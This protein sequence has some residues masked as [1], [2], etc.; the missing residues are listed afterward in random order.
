[1]CFKLKLPKRAAIVDWATTDPQI[2]GTNTGFS[3]GSKG[4]T[5]N[6]NSLFFHNRI[7]RRCTR[8]NVG[9]GMEW[10]FRVCTLIDNSHFFFSALCNHTSPQRC[11]GSMSGMPVFTIS[12]GF[13][14]KAKWYEWV[15]QREGEP[16]AFETVR[17]IIES[18]VSAESLLCERDNCCCCNRVPVW[19]GD[20]P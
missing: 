6:V 13:Q 7:R 17:N 19:A 10:R 1:M 4:P 11:C 8:N 5:C 18:E 14:I 3:W 16:C 9:V 15:T 2:R 12:P 20:D